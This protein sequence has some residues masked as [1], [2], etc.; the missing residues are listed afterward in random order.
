MVPVAA[1]AAGAGANAVTR[2]AATASKLKRLMRL[3]PIVVSLVSK[4]SRA[5]PGNPVTPMWRDGH[6]GRDG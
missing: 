3:P 6:L 5:V 1:R 4:S 2:R